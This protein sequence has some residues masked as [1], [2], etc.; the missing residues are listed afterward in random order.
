MKLDPYSLTPRTFKSFIITLEQ[1]VTYNLLANDVVRATGQFLFGGDML[2][3]F[4]DR[5]PNTVVESNTLPKT[6]VQVR[7]SAK[8]ATFRF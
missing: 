1:E 7:S 5:C 2:A 8:F 3:K 6:E 4:S